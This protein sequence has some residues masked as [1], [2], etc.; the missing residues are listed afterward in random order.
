MHNCY[1]YSVI[2][3]SPIHTYL[4]VLCIFRTSKTVNF[5]DHD[6]NAYMAGNA[7]CCGIPGHD[8]NAHMH[9]NAACCG[10]PGHDS[11]AYIHGNAAFCGTPGHD[12]NAYMHGNAACCGI[13]GHDSNARMHGCVI[14]MHAGHLQHIFFL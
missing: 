7:A 14:L 10:I 5:N 4:S 2:S 1:I 6:S 8:S 13:P 3:C 9:G 12:S 11:N